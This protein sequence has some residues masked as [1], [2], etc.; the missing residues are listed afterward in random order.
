M[1]DTSVNNLVNL[2][3]FINKGTRSTYIKRFYLQIGSI[4]CGTI[5]P[6]FIVPMMIK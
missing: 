5:I 1:N 4:I 6:I 2:S 3:R